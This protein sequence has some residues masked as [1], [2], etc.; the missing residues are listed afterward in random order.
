VGLV[1]D[2]YRVADFAPRPTRKEEQCTT[3]NLG[4]RI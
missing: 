1:D 3:T 4:R 2:F